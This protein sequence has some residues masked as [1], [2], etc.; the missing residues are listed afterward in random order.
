MGVRHGIISTWDAQKHMARH[1]SDVQGFEV[2]CS[3]KSDSSMGR[4]VPKFVKWGALGVAAVG[5][6]R[7][8]KRVEDSKL[9]FRKAAQGMNQEKPRMQLSGQSFVNAP[10]D[11]WVELA[12][13]SHVGARAGANLS[14]HMSACKMH[15]R[16][17]ILRRACREAKLELVGVKNRPVGIHTHAIFKQL[18]EQ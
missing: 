10:H 2:L 11:P 8:G 18:L 16:F 13:V 1:I 3:L 5:A 15:Q 7:A 14:T 17:N 9:F 4:A 12:D 6:G